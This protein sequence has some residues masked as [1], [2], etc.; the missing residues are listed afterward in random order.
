MTDVDKKEKKIQEDNMEDKEDESHQTRLTESIKEDKHVQK[1]SEEPSKDEKKAKKKED[2]E[3][4][5]D[6]DDDVGIDFSGIFKKKEKKE[7]PQKIDKK[8]QAEKKEKDNEEDE[9]DESFDFSKVK[10]IFK[11]KDKKQAKEKDEDSEDSDGMDLSGVSDSFKKS[12]N[13]VAKSV[14]IIPLVLL[15]VAMSFGTYIRLETDRMSVTDDWAKMSMDNS[16]TQKIT[17]D[18]NSEYP[19]LPSDKKNEIIAKEVDNVKKQYKADI[20][21]TEASLSTQYKSEFKKDI[22]DSNGNKIGETTYLVGIDPYFWMLHTENVLENGHVGDELRDGKPYD[23]HMYAPIG[24]FVPKDVFHAYFSAYLFSFMRIFNGNLDLTQFLFYLPILLSALAVIPAFFIAKRVA[25]NFGGFVAGFIIAIH[26]FFLARTIGGFAD[27]DPYNLIFP[28]FITWFFLIAIE[29]KDIKKNILFSVLAGILAGLYS[30]V[31]GGWWHIVY[32]M[33]GSGVVYLAYYIITNIK[34]IKKDS[35]FIIKD[36]NI[37]NVSILV[38]IFFLISGVLALALTNYNI[39]FSLVST[40]QGFAAMKD[41]GTASIW[42]NVLTTV[43]EQNEVTFKEVITNLGG[44]PLFLISI[45]GIILVTLKKDSKGNYDVKYSIILIIW[46]AATLYASLKGVRF[47]MMM[48]PAFAIGVG[49]ALGIILEYLSKYFSKELKVHPV[50][51]KAVLII[52][53]CLLLISP[54]QISLASSKSNFDSTLNDAWYNSLINIKENSEEDAII[55]SW[56][57]YGHWFKQ[58]ADRPVTFDGTSQDGQRAYWVGKAFL[59]SDEDVTVGIVRMLDCGSNNAFVELDKVMKNTHKSVDIINEIILLNKEEARAKLKSYGLDDSQ[60]ENVL[61][62]THCDPPEGFLIVSDDMIPKSGVWG[63]FGSWDF[64]KAE[65]FNKVKNLDKESSIKYMMSEFNYSQSSAD[66]MYAKIQ[67]LGVGKEAN[68]WIAPWPAFGSN[69]T[70]CVK[71]T[72]EIY[73]CSVGQGAVAELNVT[74]MKMTIPTNN[75]IKSPDVLTFINETGVFQVR[76]NSN[77]GIGMLIIPSEGGYISIIASKEQVSSMFAR[78]YFLEGYK[79]THFKKMSEETNVIGNR[80][81]V[82]KIDWKGLQDNKYPLFVKNE[83]DRLNQTTNQTAIV[84]E[85]LTNKSS[86]NKTSLYA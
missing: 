4:S 21:A 40:P 29:S 14:W 46:F 11:K 5:D 28:L 65:I 80:I 77:L 15:I 13:Y 71:K 39:F 74:D 9:D 51:S 36:K 17:A 7:Q 1:E 2:D 85:T 68:D 24:R 54:L 67:S 16:I 20:A 60:A 56:W 50:L 37:M 10:N 81:V 58:V 73:L 41:V 43:A 33:V 79:T 38:L 45:L 49:L 82:W 75:G 35:K 30:I 70:S 53:L 59:T 52:L 86:T 78:L 32:L 69:P 19:N 12:Y 55:T 57:D 47:V 27:T 42:P 44:M 22:F 18:I 8:K 64:E 34:E 72:E 48:I 76:S 25:G 84:N 31:W 61:K 66:A 83:L 6:E 62:N 26:P 3:D 63:H 23:T